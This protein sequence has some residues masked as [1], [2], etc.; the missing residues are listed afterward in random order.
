MGGSLKKCHK[1]YVF[2]NYDL[3]ADGKMIYLPVYMSM[4]IR[5]DTPLPVLDPI[6]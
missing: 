1:A 5:E 3:K 4:F 2:T 6:I